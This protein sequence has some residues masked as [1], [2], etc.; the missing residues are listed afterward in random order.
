MTMICY[1]IE[2]TAAIDD[3]GTTTT[4][5]LTDGEGWTTKPTDTPANTHVMPRIKQAANYRRDLF[6]RGAIGGAVESAFGEAVFANADGALDD[7]AGYGFDGRKFVV[8]VGEAK[9]AYPSGF[10]TVLTATMSAALLIGQ[11]SKFGCVT[12]LSC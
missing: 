1:V 6:T 9:A 7:W 11:N 4:L 3:A 8:R 12:V 2:I 5:L 10:T